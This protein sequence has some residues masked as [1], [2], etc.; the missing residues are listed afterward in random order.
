[1]LTVEPG[2]YIPATDERA[3]AEL[4][5]LGVRIEDDVLVRREGPE[6]LTAAVPKRVAEVE[7]AVG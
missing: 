3:P 1:M 5:G 6:V 2:L 4:R 7:A